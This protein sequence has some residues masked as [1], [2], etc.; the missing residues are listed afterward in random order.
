MKK[1]KVK[2]KFAIYSSLFKE[3]EDFRKSLNEVFHS[4]S[5][6][7]STYVRIGW[8]IGSIEIHVRQENIK[9][10]KKQIEEFMNK[11]VKDQT[12]WLERIRNS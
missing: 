4:I 5:Q 3:V 2:V 12:I 8:R 7:E 9:E 1:Q 10:V 11:T 6:V